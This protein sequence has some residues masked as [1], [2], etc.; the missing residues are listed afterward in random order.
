MTQEKTKGTAD[1]IDKHVGHR[2]RLRRSLM[3]ISQEK[4]A[5]SVGVSFQQVQKYEKGMNRISA[6]RLFQFSKFLQV[7]LSYFYDGNESQAF[8]AQGFADNEQAAFGDE[9]GP[10]IMEKKETLELIRHYYAI[11]DE[12]VRANILKLIKSVAKDQE[13]GAE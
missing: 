7:P 6:S 11:Q 5:E 3:G 12:K 9:D 10:N 4:L 2:L 8:I 13:D 1:D